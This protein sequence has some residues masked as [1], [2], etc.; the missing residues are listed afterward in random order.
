MAMSVSMPFTSGN[1]FS[2]PWVHKHAGACAA[3]T[4][5]CYEPHVIPR[6]Y[7]RR[8]ALPTTRAYMWEVHKLG[9]CARAR[10]ATVA[11]VQE[12]ERT[13]VWLNKHT[14]SH[15]VQLPLHHHPDTVSLVHSCVNQSV[16]RHP[17]SSSCLL[18]PNLTRGPQAPVGA[19]CETHDTW[20]DVICG[21]GS[22]MD[23]SSLVIPGRGTLRS[24]LFRITVDNQPVHCNPK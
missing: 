24:Y 21:S 18:Q 5:L 23:F 22:F 3:N 9:D 17:C 19:K 11:D 14:I 12:R 13:S 2:L 10:T 7:R 20:Y 6:G 16:C 8:V 1:V 4:C 15:G